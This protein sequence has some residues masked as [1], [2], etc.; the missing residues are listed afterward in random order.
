M[1]IQ[2]P[3]DLRPEMTVQVLAAELRRF[4]ADP[5]LDRLLDL[6]ILPHVDLQHSL[7]VTRLSLS[8]FDQLARPLALPPPAR[9]LLAVAAFW[10]DVG[11][12]I[13]ERGHHK[14]SQ[15]LILALEIPGW[16]QEIKQQVACI[17]RYHRKRPPCPTDDGYT[18]LDT[19]AR[20][21]V[22]RLAALLRIADGLDYS[23]RGLVRAV[24]SSI[25]E[26]VILH[27]RGPENAAMEVRR[28]QQKADFFEMAFGR[29]ASVYREED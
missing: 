1:T 21:Q 23:H 24:R 10:H 16:E 11:Q 20:G 4:P 3:A 25:T 28:A 26:E 13:S 9:G 15:T 27:A 7:W 5:A 14:H 6:P 18:A 29:K 17:A 22:L 8:L 12:V 2:P 19:A